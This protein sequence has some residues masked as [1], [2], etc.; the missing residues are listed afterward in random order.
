MYGNT[1]NF[2]NNSFFMVLSG[3]AHI[4]MTYYHFL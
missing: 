1:Y 4:C 3:K 2:I